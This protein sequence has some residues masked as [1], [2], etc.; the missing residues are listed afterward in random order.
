MT[1]LIDALQL[2]KLRKQPKNVVILDASWHMP[3]GERDAR[4]EFEAAHVAGARF[5]DLSLFDDQATSLP[6]MLTHDTAHI[7]SLL[8]ELGMS[9]DDKIIFYDQSD[10]HSSCRAWWMFKMFGHDP[11]KLF[12]EAP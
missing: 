11:E 10:L 7:A 9:P 5:F 3:T 2:D 12:I 8:R 6:H 4:A 1:Q